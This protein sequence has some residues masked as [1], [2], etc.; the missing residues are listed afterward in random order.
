MK[1]GR[2]LSAVIWNWNLLLVYLLIF[3]GFKVADVQ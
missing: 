3:V 1:V 2:I